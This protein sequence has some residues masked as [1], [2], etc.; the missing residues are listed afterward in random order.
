MG[1]GRLIK[2][3]QLKAM[4]SIQ[5]SNP[6]KFAKDAIAALE[7]QWMLAKT[8]KRKSKI[9]AKILEWKQVLGEKP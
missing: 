8:A 5:R 4:G 2:R 9:E 7:N 1:M 3:N 6:V